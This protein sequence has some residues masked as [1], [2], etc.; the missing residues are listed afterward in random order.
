MATK[1]PYYDVQREIKKNVAGLRSLFDQYQQ[2]SARDDDI[3]HAK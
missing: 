2:K 1:D 3:T